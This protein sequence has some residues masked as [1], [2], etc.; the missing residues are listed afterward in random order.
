MSSIHSAAGI[1]DILPYVDQASRYIG[2]EI[3]A[4]R[5]D[6]PNIRLNIALAFPDLYEIGTSHFGLQILYHIL[7]QNATIRAERLYAP[8]LDLQHHMKKYDIPLMSLESKR[9]INTFDIVGFSLLY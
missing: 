7:N 9:P 3:N 5:K 1:H 2:T 6:A 4:I 8:G